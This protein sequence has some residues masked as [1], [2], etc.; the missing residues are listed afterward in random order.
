METQVTRINP[1]KWRHSKHMD[2]SSPFLCFTILGD[3]LSRLVWI[4]S[5]WEASL[6]RYIWSK[7][8]QWMQEARI[9]VCR[10]WDRHCSGLA[11]C[12]LTFNT[13]ISVCFQSMQNLGCPIP[14]DKFED[15]ES[16]N[17]FHYVAPFWPAVAKWVASSSTF[18]EMSS[19]KQVC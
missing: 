10:P 11:W 18:T 15:E 17:Q 13:G 16:C 1:G 12:C 14:T 6:R 4:C 3:S 2:R 7:I 5:V 8:F 9:T 19:F